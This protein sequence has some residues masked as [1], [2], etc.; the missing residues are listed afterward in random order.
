MARSRQ[1]L[2]LQLTSMQLPQ[3][4]NAGEVTLPGSITVEKSVVGCELLIHPGEPSEIV[5]Q[6]QNLG[7][8]NLQVNMQIEGNF[9]PEWCRLGMEGRELAPG[10]Q[11]DA[12]LYFQVPATFFENTA[13]DSDS[14]TLDYQSQ[15]YIYYSESGLGRQMIDSANISLYIRPRSLYLD[16]LPSLYR[17]VDFI[18][19]FLKIFEQAFEP[20]VQS[21]DLL[22]AYLDPL[23]A[24]RELLPFLAH[25]VAWP[26]EPHWDLGQQRRLIRQA[27]EIYRWR[28]TRRGLRLYLHLYTDLPLD[29]HLPQEADKH[30]SIQEIFQ[31][32]FILGSTYLGEDCMIGGGR[33]Y[34]F[35]V[36]LRPERGSPINE[37]LVR[38]IID[39]EKPAFCTYELYI[40]SG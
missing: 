10:H 2:R 15:L 17:E 21:M 1:I 23:T 5:V 3:T 18:S 8:R 38:Y 20:A 13:I 9:P 28:G 30:I 36:H 14:L 22:W 11:M 16:F 12:I 33:P 31:A 32:G 19:R 6:L 24:P 40:Q 37:E 26:I 7:S 34:H 27:M 25:W 29:E 4:V 39:Q 35:I